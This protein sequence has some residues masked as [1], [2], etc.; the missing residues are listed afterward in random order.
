MIVKITRKARRMA[1]RI[2]AV[3]IET[4]RFFLEQSTKIPMDVMP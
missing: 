4:E 3:D 2:N 1:R